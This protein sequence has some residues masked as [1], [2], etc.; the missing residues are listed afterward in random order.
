[1]WV[2][3]T[4]QNLVASVIVATL[5]LLS[6]IL[7]VTTVFPSLPLG[8]FTAAVVGVGLAGLLWLGLRAALGRGRAPAPAERFGEA[9]FLWRM[10]PL[11]TLDPPRWSR[12][13]NVGMYLLRGYLVLAVVLLAVKVGQIAGG[14]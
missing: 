5:V 1:P 7:T 13:Q 9:K 3:T 8:P 6:L 2:N 10:A 11:A 12:A 4:R 14:H